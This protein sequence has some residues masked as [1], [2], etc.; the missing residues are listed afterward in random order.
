MTVANQKAQ[1][2]PHHHVSMPSADSADNYKAAIKQL[3]A[4]EKELLTG[5]AHANVS[6]DDLR[7]ILKSIDIYNVDLATIV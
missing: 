5:K 1:A 6:T 7:V 2:D 3:K 4:Y